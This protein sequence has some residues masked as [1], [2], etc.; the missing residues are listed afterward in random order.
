MWSG[1]N[2]FSC[3]VSHFNI[4]T[5]FASQLS[6]FVYQLFGSASIYQNFYTGVSA[7]TLS[8]YRVAESVLSHK[9]SHT[10]TS[11]FLATI[12]LGPF[13]NRQHIYF[14]SLLIIFHWFPHRIGRKKAIINFVIVWSALRYIDKKTFL[15]CSFKK[16]ARKRKNLLL[17]E[18]FSKKV[19][20]QHR[21]LYLISSTSPRSPHSPTQ[22]Y[23]T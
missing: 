22:I 15:V 8:Q 18:E 7:V 6:L 11:Q 17:V 12:F 23:L 13:S 10:L 20:A 5:V 9:H 14:L 21:H 3:F 16:M 4:K 2:F 19:N 1:N